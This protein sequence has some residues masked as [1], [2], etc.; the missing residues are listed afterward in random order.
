MDS[1]QLQFWN[2]IFTGAY[3]ILTLVIAGATIW[4][5]ILTRASLNLT[6]E[7]TE[8]NRKQSEDALIASEKQSQ[9]AMKAVHEQIQASEKQNREQMENQFKP[10][11]MP[12]GKPETGDNVAYRLDLLNQGTGI[13]LKTWGFITMRNFPQIYYFE[14]AYSIRSHEMNMHKLVNEDIIYPTNVFEGYPIFLSGDESGIKQ[15]IR[16]LVTYNDIFNNK[17]LII[18]DYSDE[19]GWQLVDFKKVEK[20]LDELAEKKRQPTK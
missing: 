10:F 4:S 8:I 1:V 9:A 7:Q 5:L 6:R 11:I 3:V 14:S 18:F 17:F 13:A 2:D 16:L 12:V 20:R 19:F 15:I